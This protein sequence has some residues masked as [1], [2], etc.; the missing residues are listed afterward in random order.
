MKSTTRNEVYSW[1]K[2]VMF[3]LIIGFLCSKFLFSPTSVHGESMAPTFQNQDRVLISKTADIQR[4]DTIVF[5]APDADKYY[6]KRVIGLPGDCLE[7][8]NDVLYINGKEVAEP[9]LEGNKEEVQFEKLTGD[10]TLREFTGESKVPD[11]SLFV[12]GDNRLHSKDSRYFGFVPIDSV[13]GEVIFRFY[14]F[15]NIGIPN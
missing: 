14:P 1:I 3:G 6:L 8:K 13:V 5:H 12:M 4:F 7:M 9:Y 11:G 15:K 2:S 10:F